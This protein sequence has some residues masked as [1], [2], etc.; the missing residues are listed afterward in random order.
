M[1]CL[2]TNIIIDFLNNHKDTVDKIREILDKG[3]IFITPISL[4]E[5]YKGI[6]LY[7]N[8]KEELEIFDEILDWLSI[9]EFDKSVC[10]EFGRS[11]NKL[12]KIGKTIPEFDLMISCFA[13]INNLILITRDKKHFEDIDAKVEVW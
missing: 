10:N 8:V 4:C 13:K 9:L 6:Y 1:Y 3:D 7:G 5:I 2:D 11:Y 12:K